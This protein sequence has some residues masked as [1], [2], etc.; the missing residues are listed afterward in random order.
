MESDEREGL[1]RDYL[2]KLLP[3]NWRTM[4]LYER[5]SFLNGGSI[6]APP[7]GTCERERVCT[8]EI[9]C[10]CFGKEPVSL[11][12]T[13]AFELNALM[14][15][16]GGWKKYDGNK[17]GTFKFPIYGMQRGYVREVNEEVNEDDKQ[18]G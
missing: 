5:R 17:Q 1:V 2:E 11:R 14:M 10:E 16:I 6:G 9:W 12:K 3:E 13:D 7:V 18:T 15:R 4:E 8:L